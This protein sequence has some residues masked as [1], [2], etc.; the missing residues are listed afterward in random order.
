MAVDHVKSTFVTNLDASPAVMNTAGEGAGGLVKSISGSNVA[1]AA[2]S[3]DATYQFVRV[4]SNCKVSAIF[5]ESAAQAAG[6]L[7]IGLYFATDG[8]GGKPLS[9]LAANAIDQDF[10]AS[11]VAVT[12]LSQPTNVVNESGT[13]TIDK[14]TQPLW[15]A[16]GLTADPGGFFD[17]V[18]TVVTAITTGTGR[19]G[20]TVLYTD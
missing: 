8:Q 6:T 18:G 12:A 17:I 5:F 15:Q 11:L 7:D 13:N 14:R 1:V 2:S 16:V 19:W 4:P 3:T 9:L 20:M 10:F